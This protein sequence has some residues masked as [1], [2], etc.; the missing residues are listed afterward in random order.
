MIGFVIN[1]A[2]TGIVCRAYL[3]AYK[4]L[5]STVT[6]LKR[7]LTFYNYKILISRFFA[8]Y[9]KYFLKIN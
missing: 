4:L 5:K 7:K 8:K 1:F 6:R 9:G 3:Y 2:A